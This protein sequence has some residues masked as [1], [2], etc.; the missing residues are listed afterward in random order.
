MF[1]KLKFND[2]HGL[3][4]LNAKNKITSYLNHDVEKHNFLIQCL[5]TMQK[6]AGEPAPCQGGTS[7][8]A[9]QPAQDQI[10]TPQHHSPS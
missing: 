1:L 4:M 6:L 10:I 7:W 2:F 5:L 9:V 8:Q 3:F